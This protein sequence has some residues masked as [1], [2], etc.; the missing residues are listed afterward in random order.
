MHERRSRYVCVNATGESPTC[1][2]ALKRLWCGRE[3]TRD[4][5]V[6]LL[7]DGRTDFL[8]GFRGKNGRPFKG[9]IVAATDGKP[10]FE[11]PQRRVKLS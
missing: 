10:A 7:R 11:F 5:A 3:I 9:R 6:W 2:F 8:E 1:G 4:E